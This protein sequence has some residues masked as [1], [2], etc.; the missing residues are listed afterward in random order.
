MINSKVLDCWQIGQTICNSS[1]LF[2]VLTTPQDEGYYGG[3]Y[4]N[5]FSLL[6]RNIS[7]VD[8]DIKDALNWV[9]KYCASN[10]LSILLED[11][12]NT[13]IIEGWKQLDKTS[14]V[15]YSKLIL[16]RLINHKEIKEHN[17]F[18]SYI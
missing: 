18:L 5:F 14:V 16:S 11:F 7:T 3:A 15:I 10:E 6:I 9:A 8:I 17:K 1:E 13:I 2:Q 4:S 12:Y